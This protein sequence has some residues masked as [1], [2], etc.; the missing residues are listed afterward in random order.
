METK[1]R[2]GAMNGVDQDKAVS[3]ETQPDS[4]AEDHLDTESESDSESAQAEATEEKVTA[5]IP[6]AA[7]GNVISPEAAGQ[8]VPTSTDITVK[9]DPAD[10]K[11][12]PLDTVS[13]ATAPSSQMLASMTAVPGANS[14]QIV[15]PVA[16]KAP[17][18][19]KR[20]KAAHEV[21][22]PCPAPSSR[23]SPP[24]RLTVDYSASRGCSTVIPV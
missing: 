8:S 1:E 23:V 21:F 16:Q 2:E 7:D 4:Q 3:M 11:A 22:D 24:H 18:A 13:A 5:A 10:F 14:V 19:P 17:A 20:F 6:A 15:L 9:S 12:E